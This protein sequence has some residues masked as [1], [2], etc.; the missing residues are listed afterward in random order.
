MRLSLRSLGRYPLK[1]VCRSGVYMGNNEV[2]LN[3]VTVSITN[4]GV[5]KQA[6]IC[7]AGVTVV[8]GNNCTGKST[9]LRAISKAC[10]SDHYPS[11]LTLNRVFLSE[12]STIRL[13][14]TLQIEYEGSTVEVTGNE[15]G[16]SFV[17]TGMNPG[18][19]HGEK[20]IEPMLG[21]G[22]GREALGLKGVLGINMS[23]ESSSSELSRDYQLLESLGMSETL[24]DR[25]NGL[26]GGEEAHGFIDRAGGVRPYMMRSG[27][28]TFCTLYCLIADGDLEKGTVVIVDNAESGLSPEWQCKL[29]EILI[30]IAK[31]FGVLVCL[32][33]MSPYILDAVEVYAERHKFSCNMRY[34]LG[35]RGDAGVTFGDQ[36]ESTNEI[37]KIMSRPFKELEN[38]RYAD[39][40]EL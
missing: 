18:E 31:E 10:G 28:K 8:S 22:M 21:T 38:E 30:L 35:E 27:F 15:I 1:S 26:F 6:S 12:S 7:L 40:E 14:P 39:E 9:V 25:F 13:I 33:T 37:Y 16:L 4:V 5:V 17:C 23:S 20:L 2:K 36:T 29:A 32:T 24:R 3:G 34:Y 11:T 19:W